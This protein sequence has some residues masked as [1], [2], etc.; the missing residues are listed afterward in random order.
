MRARERS[1]FR[2]GRSLCSLSTTLVFL[3]RFLSFRHRLRTAFV[4][5]SLFTSL[6]PSLFSLRSLVLVHS[7]PLYLFVCRLVLIGCLS[8][9]FVHGSV[10]LLIFP[11]NAC[12]LCLSLFLSF[13]HSFALSFTRSLVSL[14]LSFSPSL[15]H[16]VLSCCLS[17]SFS[18][19]RL[20]LIPSPLSLP[21]PSPSLTC[22][23][24]SKFGG[25]L[26]CCDFC[27]RTYHG[28][29][30]ASRNLP[31][32]PDD[33]DCDWQCSECKKDDDVDESYGSE[34]RIDGEGGVVAML[35]GLVRKLHER[36]FG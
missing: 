23:Y 16:S 24:C 13:S 33:D 30:I 34:D 2:G 28:P 36:D 9:R 5:F 29:C 21:L 32:P 4:R 12:D 17:F 10:F 7:S 14:L 35:E 8:F 6:P 26:L 22:R 18:F 27:P 15:S 25:S 11:S 1:W 31:P 19:S 3:E 20:F